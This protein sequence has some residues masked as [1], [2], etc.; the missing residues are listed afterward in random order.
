MLFASAKLSLEDCPREGSN[1]RNKYQSSFETE[2]FA[3]VDLAIVSHLEYRITV[4]FFN[5]IFFKPLKLV[6]VQEQG[7]R[8]EWRLGQEN[9]EHCQ[10]IQKL[11]GIFLPFLE[12]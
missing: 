7:G 4:T 5:P 1:K 12:L 6:M 3:T 9:I 2:V 10:K 11:A 8:P